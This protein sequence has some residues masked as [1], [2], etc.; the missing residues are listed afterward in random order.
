MIK[1]LQRDHDLVGLGEVARIIECD[2]H[3]TA[4][5]NRIDVEDGQR[6]NRQ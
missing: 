2:T 3:I 1:D 5:G 6:E 4:F